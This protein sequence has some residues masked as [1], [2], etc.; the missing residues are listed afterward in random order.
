MKSKDIQKIVKNK[1]ENGNGP[2]NIYRDLTGVVSFKT[3]K[4]WIKLIKNTVSINLSPPSGYSR[5]AGTKSNITKAKWRLD[6]KRMSTRILAT[7]MNISK[8]SAL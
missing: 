1:Y 3:I 2:T 7:E 4:L 6:K 8:T 5:T